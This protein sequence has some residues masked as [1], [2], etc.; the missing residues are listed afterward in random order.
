MSLGDPALT[1]GLD[2][3]SQAV[4]EL[5]R[6]EGVLFVI[7]AGNSGS[8]FSVSAPGAA[9][10]ALTVAAVDG[11]DQRAWFSSMGPRSGDHALKPDIAAPGVDVTAARS[12]LLPFGEGMY[13]PMDGTSMAT[14]HVAGAAAILAAAHPAWSPRRLKDALMSSAKALPGTT[15]YEVGTGRLD[16]PGG[17]RARARH[18][19]G[20]PRL[21]Q[22]AAR[23]RRSG[24]E[25]RSRTRTTVRRPSRLE[26]SEDVAGPGGGAS[27]LFDL[28]QESVT[29]PAGGSVDVERHRRRGRRA[30]GRSLHG[31][32]RRDRCLGHRQGAHRDRPRE[33]GGALRPERP[34][35]RPGR[36]AGI[37]LRRALRLPLAVGDD[38]PARPE[39]GRG[40]DAAG[41][42]RPL[43]HLDLD[44]RARVERPGLRRASRSSPSR[45]SC[46]SRD[47]EVV[48]DARKAKR[49]T[50][51]TPRPSEDRHRRMQYFHDAGIPD[52]YT[53]MDL[54]FVPAERR[55][56]V[57]RP[58]RRCGPGRGVRLHHPVATQRAAPGRVRPPP[59][60]DGRRLPVPGRVEPPRRQ[61]AARRGVRGHRDRGRLRRRGRERQGRRDPSQRRRCSRGTGSPPRRRQG[62]SC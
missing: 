53:F 56:H 14:P 42:A 44:G 55:R 15:P 3:M 27:D 43:Q 10:A 49:I 48:L 35:S 17:S 60:E 58:D 30:G 18:R 61:G 4:N 33:G 2:P 1:D 21:L 41:R 40:G 62:P 11:L 47:Q 34:R 46:S 36:H 32:R 25:A 7:A 54:Y 22:V 19:L 20:L 16:I 31:L 57:R 26:L 51:T 23:R 12:Q 50:V 38:P 28:S 5:T 52:G 13:Q 24:V 39:T 9:D 6:D 45:T 37:R 8:E 29:V 59:R